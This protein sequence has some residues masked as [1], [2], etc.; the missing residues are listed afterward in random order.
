MSEELEKLNE[1]ANFLRRMNS[2]ILLIKLITQAKNEYD[3]YDYE[4]GKASLED[5]YKI[6]PENSTVLR[7]LGCFE[8]MNENFE[9]ALNYFFKALEFSKNKEIEYTLIGMVYYFIDK[10]EDAVKYFNLAIDINE[11]Y[12]SAYEGKN[13]AMLERHLQIIDL[14]ESLEKRVNNRSL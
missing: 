9:G 11:D 3:K 4:A 2:K 5:A 14:Q 7:G 10:L 1:L 6:D 8:Q 13:Q 12:S